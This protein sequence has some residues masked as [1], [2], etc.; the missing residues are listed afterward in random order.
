MQGITISASRP[1]LVKLLILALMSTALV[2]PLARAN[3]DFAIEQGGCTPDIEK[4]HSTGLSDGI[5]CGPK[6]KE[7]CC[8]C[9][10]CCQQYCVCENP[11]GC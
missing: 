9:Q 2:T 7:T 10:A 11:Y 8:T 4:P 3:D 5:A 6:G 1:L